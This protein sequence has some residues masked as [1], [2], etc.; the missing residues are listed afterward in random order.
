MEPGSTIEQI[1]QLEQF[2]LNR[3][4][5]HPL[6]LN[7]DDTA[8]GSGKHY[9]M[10]ETAKLRLRKQ[11]GISFFIYDITTANLIQ[12][13]DSKTFAIAH[14]HI[15]HRTLNNCLINGTLYLNRFMLSIETITEM[16]NSSEFILTSNEFNTL[17]DSVR[18]TYKVLIQS[19]RKSFNAY[20]VKNPTSPLC[21]KYNSMNEFARLINGD[22]G[23]IRAFVNGEKPAG[24]L[25]KDEWLL[26]AVTR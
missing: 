15:D 7:S 13:F 6:N 11:R 23:T 19:T 14:M 12:V 20:N 1:L 26:T 16:N 4:F 3:Y 21:G 24:S 22:R 8:S 25:Y 9:P 2:Y 10:S 5:N 17:L 18:D